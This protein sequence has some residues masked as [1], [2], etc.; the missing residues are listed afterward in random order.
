MLKLTKLIENKLIQPSKII[1]TSSF[2]SQLNTSQTQTEITERLH[3]VKQQVEATVN[4]REIGGPCRLVAVSKT[5]PVSAII[6][7]YEAGQRHFGENY[8]KELLSKATD[9][10]ILKFCPEIRWHFIGPS[11][12]SS[13]LKTVLKCPNL[14]MI[15][16]IQNIKSV[17]L[18]NKSL[19]KRI[20]MDKINVMIQINTSH[21]AQKG[22]VFPGSD[23]VSLT[24]YLVTKAPNLCLKGF[25]T[26]GSYDSQQMQGPNPDFL[27][28]VETRSMI[29]KELDLDPSMFELSMGMSGD[30]EEA[31]RLGSNNVRVGSTIF[32][33]RESKM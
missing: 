3:N 4:S 10:D 29:C 15:E 8:A 19:K 31:I 7:C 30:F 14:F 22:G 26:I 13:S 32:G 25:M 27:S 20:S 2:V 1:S 11:T 9:K 5:K 21:E 16:T 6:A 33:A 23:A 12:Q 28:L 24:H 18:L 17:E